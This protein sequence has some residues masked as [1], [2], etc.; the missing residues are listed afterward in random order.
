MK[1]KKS[2]FMNILV[3]GRKDVANSSTIG[4]YNVRARRNL[5]YYLV[6]MLHS[7]GEEHTLTV[8]LI[9]EHKLSV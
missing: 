1:M 5:R 4:S 6:Q 7:R 9:I 8:D 3:K 2:V